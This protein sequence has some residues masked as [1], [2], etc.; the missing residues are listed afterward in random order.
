[1]ILPNLGGAFSAFPPANSELKL[2][3]FRKGL[4]YFA[5]VQFV[6]LSR[7]DYTDNAE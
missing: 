5:V 6:G 3:A 4:D 2:S 7:R 1:M